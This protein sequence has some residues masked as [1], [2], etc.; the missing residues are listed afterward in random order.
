MLYRCRCI[1]ILERFGYNESHEIKATILFFILDSAKDTV[2]GIPWSLY[3][4]FVIEERH[5]FNKQS[6]GL[7][8][9]DLLKQV[10]AYIF[11]CPCAHAYA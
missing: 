6:L 5:G 9:V 10:C 7:F 2:L 1:D 11:A 4:T 8:F 3:S